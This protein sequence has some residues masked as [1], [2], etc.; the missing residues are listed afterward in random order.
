MK[1]L[2]TIASLSV[3]LLL[4]S[5]LSTNAQN[6]GGSFVRQEEIS[7]LKI[8]ELLR[9]DGFDVGIDKDGDV[10]VRNLPG[11]VWVWVSKDSERPIIQCFS[12]IEDGKGNISNS[13]L[14]A[15]NKKFFG[16]AVRD[17]GRINYEWTFVTA[18][19]LPERNLVL[20]LG[21]CINGYQSFLKELL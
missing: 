11:S 21:L 2:T 3:V 1:T 19:G 17:S 13:K 15:Y 12:F 6:N 7:A 5:V 20:N 4:F 14:D 10:E 18:V 9:L 8:R 16:K